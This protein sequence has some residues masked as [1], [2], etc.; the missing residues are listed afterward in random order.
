MKL[1]TGKHTT[2]RN[3]QILKVYSK[4]YEPKVA[5]EK[6]PIVGIGASAGGLEA[7]ELFF[8]NLPITTGMAF[9][10]IQ[11]LD[12]NHEG[13]LPEL[14]QRKTGMKVL[15]ASDR[16]KV[17]PNNV[18]VIPPNKSLSILNGILHLFDPVEIRG[19]RLPIDIFFRS[20]AADRKE[21]SVGIILSGMGS[22]GCL[23]IR[24]IKEQNGLVMVQEPSSAKFDSMPANAIR[25]VTVDIIAPVEELPAKLIEFL[26]FFPIKTTKIEI[27]DKSNIEKIVILLRDQSGHDFSMYKKSTLMRRIER[28]KGIHGFEDLNKYVRFLQKNP[29]EVELLF[30]ELLIGV[31]SFFRDTAVWKKFKEEI[32]PNY[33]KNLPDNYMLRAWVTACSTGEEAYSLAILFKE[34]LSEME[35]DRGLSLQIFASDIDIHAIEKARKGFFSSNIVADVSPERINKYFKPEAEGFRVNSDI[36]EMLVFAPHDLIKD[37]PFTKLD[38]LTC[39]NMLIYMEPPLQ[40]KLMALFNYSLKP[41]GIMLLGTAETLGQNNTDFEIIDSRLKFFKKTKTSK[42]AEF[43]DFP[44]SFKGDKK[45]LIMNKPKPKMTENIQ[46]LADQLLLQ[47]FAPASVLVN[48]NGD[49]LYITGRTGKY[50][51]PVAGKANWNIH[52]MAREGLRN[53]L[54]G[55]FRKAKKTFEPVVISKIKIGNDGSFVLADVTLQRIESPEEIK[56]MIFIVFNELPK[57]LESDSLNMKSNIQFGKDELKELE[58]ELK[59]SNIDLQIT[60]EEMQTSQEELKSSNEELQSTNEELQSTNEELTTSKE[61]M[62]SLNEELQTINA[63]LQSKLI[64]FEQA[65]NDM[66]NLLNSTDIATLF[67]D[68]DLNIRRFTDPVCKIF[69]LRTSDIGRPFTDL[70]TELEYPEMKLHALEVIKN[71]TPIQTKVSTKDGRWFYVK[72]IPYRTLDD[73]IDGLVITFIDITSSKTAEEALNYENRYLRLFESTKDGIL[74]LNAETG[75]I[76]DVNPFLIKKL[77]YSHEQFLQKTIWEIGLFK[78]IKV[79]KDKFLEL[80]SENFVQYENLPLETAN[81]KI[82]NVEFVSTVFAVNNNKII[83]CI[84]REIADEQKINDSLIISPESHYRHLFESINEGVL[85]IDANAGTV[86]D[87]N[88]YLINLLGYP[89]EYFFEKQIWEMEFFKAI[90]PNK[91]KFLELQQREFINYEDVLIKVANGNKIFIE[92]ISNIYY[93]DYDK[94]IQCFIH[95]VNKPKLTKASLK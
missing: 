70:V 50:L 51:E 28:R 59:Q 67:L 66:K 54:P 12:P 22:D 90:V 17:K 79:N 34:V 65:N 62:Q 82:I 48:E 74:I 63:E 56:G 3:S 75:K 21:K 76:I 89:K 83:Q 13:I 85:F 6:F 86:I 1:N 7:F 44:S 27:K 42:L 80:Q 58:A 11:H 37:P 93:K 20:L 41:D 14:I 77:G 47:R 15:Q 84:V 55:A 33:L 72:I 88:E 92:F 95:E 91:D 29:R 78:D 73:R 8:N 23:G 39:R 9:V 16:L 36:R 69:K 45:K 2:N 43:I 35:N 40:K 87:I 31:T 46:T 19:L 57:I 61:E 68:M 24:A 38:L 30:N 60:R 4:S 26:K 25:A 32:L 81:G 64:D 71:L 94:I 10:I 53:V 5:D 49:I 52:A 18:Y